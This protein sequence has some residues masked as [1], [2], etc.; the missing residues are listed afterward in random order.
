MSARLVSDAQVA[1]LT[2]VAAQFIAPGG[3]TETE[4]ASQVGLNKRSL[5]RLLDDGHLARTDTGDS[6][7]DGGRFRL[8]LTASGRAQL[9]LAI[10]RRL[11]PA[12]MFGRPL[13]DDLAEGDL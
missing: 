8:H 6:N 10:E 7:T 13:L 1:I 11:V 9:R 4:G 12:Q 2:E 3:Y 5:R